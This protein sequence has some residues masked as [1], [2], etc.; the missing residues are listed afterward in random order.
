M[1]SQKPKNFWPWIILGGFSLLIVLDGILAVVLGTDETRLSSQTA[2]GDQADRKGLLL[3]TT[4][5]TAAL[6]DLQGWV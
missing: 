6:Q 5:K 2:T 4:P 1:E 3:E